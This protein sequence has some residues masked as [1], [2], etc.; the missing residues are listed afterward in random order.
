VIKES[1]NKILI[2]LWERDMSPYYINEKW[3]IQPNFLDVSSSLLV[4]LRPNT[5]IHLLQNLH[6]DDRQKLDG[7]MEASRITKNK[8]L[9]T[10]FNLFSHQFSA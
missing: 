4:V 3:K 2:I 6:E 1:C 9:H 10:L 5:H 7:Q 8:I